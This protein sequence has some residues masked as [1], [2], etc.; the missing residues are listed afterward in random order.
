[1]RSGLRNKDWSYNVT[2]AEI[3]EQRLKLKKASQRRYMAIFEQMQNEQPD[4]H[5][6]L[7]DMALVRYASPKPEAFTLGMAIWL[8]YKVKF[9]LI[10]TVQNKYI[11][12][13][14]SD[15]L[16]PSPFL[17]LIQENCLE[18]TVVQKSVSLLPFTMMLNG[19]ETALNPPF[20]P[21]SFAKMFR[22]LVRIE[23]AQ[24]LEK[25]ATVTAAGQ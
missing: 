3:M 17:R 24:Y 5:G 11:G 16:E 15:I 8:A 25:G 7:D 13:N 6:F 9:N 22:K 14:R 4:L 19:L 12:A 23:N 1:M 10:E 2:K 18:D 20:H 21:T